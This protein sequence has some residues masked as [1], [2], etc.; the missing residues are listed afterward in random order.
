MPRIRTLKPEIHQDEAVGELSDAA[1]RLYVGLITQADDAG[2]LKGSPRLLG[3]LIWPYQPKTPK[4]IETWLAELDRAGLILRYA[5]AGRPFICLPSWAEHQR[6]DN[7]AKSRIP[8]PDATAL[9]KSRRNSASRGDPP[10]DQ[11]RDQGSRT[12]DS[13]PTAADAP[14]CFLLA[15]LIEANGSKRPTVTKRWADAERLMLERDERDPVKAERLLRWC[16]A[17]EFWC[18]NILSMPKFRDQY[19]QLRLHANRKR[20]TAQQ[21]ADSGKW[22]PGAGFI[23]EE[24]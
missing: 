20:D 16:Q 10:L 1:F 8:E 15:D 5:H 4:E 6:V 13:A 3:S 22:E 14:L 18:S 9:E 17:D 24:A 23:E 12:K 11:G 21:Q 7:A 2:R 19:D